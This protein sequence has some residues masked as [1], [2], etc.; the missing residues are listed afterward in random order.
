MHMSRMLVLVLKDGEVVDHI[1]RISCS[2][3]IAVFV[4][5]TLE[6]LNCTLPV[7]AVTR[8]SIVKRICLIKGV[9]YAIKLCA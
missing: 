2:A 3:V 7:Y 8:D 6:A 5:N 4:Y 1:P 9:S